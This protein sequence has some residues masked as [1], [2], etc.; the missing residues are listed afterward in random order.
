MSNT[1]LLAVALA[2]KSKR[3]GGLKVADGL[4]RKYG[5]EVLPGLSLKEWRS[6]GGIGSA[7]VCRLKAVFELG[8]R[9]FAA[10][11]EERGALSS[12]TEVYSHV[13]DLCRARKEHL[14]ALYLDGQNRLIARETISIGNLNT[15]GTH[16]REVLQPAIACSALSFILVHNHPNGDASPSREDVGFTRAIRRAA[17]IV[18][19]GLHDH[20]IVVEDGY[21]SMKER[22]LL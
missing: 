6:D 13:R 15:T 3:G 7:T 14:V 1:E 20:L 17:R 12:P 16:P 18:G 2:P 22:G 21:V 19:I 10:R 9:A 4:L 11:D 8:R 5:L